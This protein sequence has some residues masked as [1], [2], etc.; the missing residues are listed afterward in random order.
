MTTQAVIDTS[1]PT[2]QAPRPFKFDR[3]F[4]APALITSVLLAGQISFGFLESWSRTLLA[5][6]TAIGVELV[7]YRAL[8]GKWPHLASAYV[9]GISAGILVRSPAYWPYALCSAL[10]IT[11]KYVLRVR[12]RH[13][14]NPTNFAV[15]M[16]LLL[17]PDAMAGLSIQWGNNLLPMIFVWAFGSVILWMVDRLNIT[18][19]YV[20]AFVIFAA[21]RSGITGHP[22]LSEVAP[23][24]G[25]MYQL[26]IFFMI[27][28]PKTTVGPKWAQA[29]VVVIIAA[30]E[31]VFRLEQFVY[32][33]FYALFIV[34][35]IANLIEIALTAPKP[36]A[37]PPQ[38]AR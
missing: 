36:A 1:R 7:V 11:S 33:P 14:W 8:Y 9:S 2:P 24:T 10:A 13:I 28:D 26:F 22:L 29:V 4:L 34:G 5:I 3:R 6:A 19:T 20:I 31:S 30:L 18:I 16:L 23:L 37:A 32:A 17:A 21:M 27:T 38:S 25:P 35:P 12:G 15:V